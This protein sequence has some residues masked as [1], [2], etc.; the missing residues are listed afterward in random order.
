V[1][2]PLASTPT[3]PDTPVTAPYSPSARLR[4]APSAKVTARID[5]AAGG[6]SA[7]P[8]PCRARAPIRSPADPATPASSEADENSVNPVTSMRRRPKRSAILPPSS[9]NP[10]SMRPYAMMIH[11]RV[12]FPMPRSCWIEGRATFTTAISSTTMNCAAHART[13]IIPLFVCAL[14]P[15]VDSSYVSMGR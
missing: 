6:M 8:K 1:S 5:S 15:T 13:R 12:L 9:R 11:C 3:D 10:P 4:S 14:V 7:A 2:R